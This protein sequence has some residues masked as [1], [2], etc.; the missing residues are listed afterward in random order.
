MSIADLLDMFTYSFVQRAL[1]VGILVSLCAALLG[2]ILVLKHYSLIGHGL[3]EVGFG[4]LSLALAL[5]LPPLYVSI[6]IVVAASFLIMFISQKKG[7]HGDVAIGVISTGALAVGIIITALTKGFNVDVYNYM[8]GSVLAMSHDDVI[9]SIVLSIIVI[10]LYILFYNRLFMITYDECY[11]KACG[12][13][14]TFYQFL[15]S[16]LTALTI[17]LGMRIMGTMLISSLIIFPAL[18]SRKLVVSFKKAIML[19]ALFSVVCF[20]IGLIL[21]FVLNLPTGA[22]IVIV[23][24]VVLAVVSII[25]KLIKTA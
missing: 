1:L 2:V 7:V 25:S 8:F 23:N 21:S 18:I 13:N 9:L 19:S 14:V 5:Q 3:A 6:P 20:V 22:S 16:F 24:V 15:I 12:I 11:A 10:S 4:A 17:V